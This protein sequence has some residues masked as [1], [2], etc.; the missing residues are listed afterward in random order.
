MTA[1]KDSISDLELVLL[2]PDPTI[3]E[4]RRHIQEKC[5]TAV[6]TLEAA[7]K[8]APFLRKLENWPLA[9]TS[10][11]LANYF[12]KQIAEKDLEEF[13]ALFDLE[14]LTYDDINLDEIMNWYD[15]KLAPFSEKKKAEFP[16]ALAIAALE[17]YRSSSDE[18]IAVISRDRDFKEACERFSGLMYFPSLVAYSEALRSADE[19][20]SW[21]QNGMQE[22]SDTVNELISN[23]F[24]E[25]GFVADSNWD[26]E[27]SD[28]EVTNYEGIRF[29][30]VGIG[31]ERCTIAFE[32]E[33]EY[34][35]SV[36]YDD[37]ESATYEKGIPVAIHHRF[38]GSVSDTADVSGTVVITIDNETSSINE[39]DRVELDD[40]DYTIYAQPEP[41]Y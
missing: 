17:A 20:L 25:C 10:P 38:E 40:A 3:R 4:I 2:M 26:A 19:R 6:R 29:R 9:K 21:I 37:L 39:I 36:A 14:E 28:I 5:E 11:Q 41:I 12:L 23:Q 15:R 34:S 13:L 35:A 24:E 1:F 31:Q 16:D 8:K 7:A 18:S 22:Q 32:G 30:V 33:I 27:I